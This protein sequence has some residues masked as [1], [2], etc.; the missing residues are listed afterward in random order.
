MRSVRSMA[1]GRWHWL[2]LSGALLLTA[3]SACGGGATWTQESTSGN[4]P[5]PVDTACT[6]SGWCTVPLDGP[7]EATAT[8][9]A[10]SPPGP[11]G[12]P[13]GG[14]PVSQKSSA[15]TSSVHTV[16]SRANRELAETNASAYQNASGQWEMVVGTNT[17]MNTLNVAE[18]TANFDYGCARDS[19][20]TWCHWTMSSSLGLFGPDDTLTY[21][22]GPTHYLYMLKM[23]SDTAG[24]RVMRT[25][26]PCPSSCTTPSW[27]ICNISFSGIDFPTVRWRPDNDS[28]YFTFVRGGQIYVGRIN[29]P[30]CSSWSYWADPDA[31]GVSGARATFD[32][33]GKLHILFTTAGGIKHQVFDPASGFVHTVTTVADYLPPTNRCDQ[34]TWP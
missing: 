1:R 19:Y 10:V 14:E 30:W 13:S 16:D 9:G 4:D 29:E 12:G 24:F 17:D 26:D 5:A 25:T 32:E 28:I 15:L 31:S 27:S 23:R 22:G 20:T 11:S 34:P 6:G 18:D 8:G 7:V 3:V 33:S 2:A 21:R